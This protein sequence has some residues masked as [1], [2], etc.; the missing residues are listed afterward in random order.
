[1]FENAI[2][3]V[4]K[5]IAEIKNPYGER[6]GTYIITE[7]LDSEDN[8][9]KILNEKKTLKGCFSEIS[10]K[11]RKNADGNVAMID[12]ETVF[13][14]LREYYGISNSDVTA[15]SPEPAGKVLSFADFL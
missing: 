6:L 12:S 3:K 5:E 15:D 2:N 4:N 1:M 13:G 14:W 11:A 9:A 10:S 7:L 8:A